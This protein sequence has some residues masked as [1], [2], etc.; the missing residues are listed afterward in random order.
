MGN[1]PFDWT[2]IENI[3]FEWIWTGL[4]VLFI[5][6]ELMGSALVTI[7]FA[8]GSVFAL[9]SKFLGLDPTMQVLVFLLSSIL[10]LLF[11]RPIAKKLMSKNK[12]KIKT[13]TDSLLGKQAKVIKR[14]SEHEY[15]QIKVDGQ[16][17]TAAAENK[18]DLFDV[19]TEV[20]VT[21]IT[22]VKLLVKKD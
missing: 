3:P 4:F 17:W 16:I 18:S 5:V 9:I 12:N 1:I 20:T 15:G 22:G 19:D 10:L 13:N 14:I 21:G 2:W 6:I 7:W 11:T 8:F